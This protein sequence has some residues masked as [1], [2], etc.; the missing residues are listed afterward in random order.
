[1]VK[2]LATHANVEVDTKL[3]MAVHLCLML[4]HKVVVKLIVVRDDVELNSKNKDGCLLLSYAAQYWREAVV[5][6][7]VVWDEG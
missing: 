2:L 4:L 6:I 1:M 3:S 5:K 7:L